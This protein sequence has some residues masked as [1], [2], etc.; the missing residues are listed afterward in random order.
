MIYRNGA[1]VFHAQYG[2]VEALGSADALHYTAVVDGLP[3]TLVHDG[4]T[5]ATTGITGMS[6]PLISPDGTH[7]GVVA[8]AQGGVS[9]VDGV[10]MLPANDI[11]GP[12]ELTDSG[13]WAVVVE[14]NDEPWVDGVVKGP[15][16]NQVVITSDA[17]DVAIATNSGTVL[18]NGNPVDTAPAQSSWLEVDGST[19]HVYS[20]V[21]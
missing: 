7:Y 18:V 10:T 9:M 17:K 5:V 19:L 13:D 6:T 15:S 20:I 16:A 1:P 4:K 3:L 2:I 21:A 12:A 8:N 14:G 11:G